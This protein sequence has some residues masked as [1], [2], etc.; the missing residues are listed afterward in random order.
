[1]KRRGVN[2]LW[3]PIF[4]LAIIGVLLFSL[5]VLAEGGDVDPY[6]LG[7]IEQQTVFTD[8]GLLEI[9]AMLINIFM[10][11]L[12]MIAVILMIYAGYLWMT[13]GGNPEK[14]EKARMIIQRA[15]IGL[16]IIFSAWA[17]VTFVFYSLGV[18][19]GDGGRQSCN[20]ENPCPPGYQCVDGRCNRIPDY[21]FRTRE[22]ELT[23]I[24]G[25]R[26]QSLDWSRSTSRYTSLVPVPPTADFQV[27][28]YAFKRN[29]IIALLALYGGLD[30]QS[31]NN[32]GTYPITISE[33]PSTEVEEWRGVD[34]SAVPVG[35]SIYVKN[36]ANSL[37]PVSDLQSSFES[38]LLTLRVINQH[39]FNGV[40]DGDETEIDCGGSCGACAGQSCRTLEDDTCSDAN[41]RSG[42][43]GPDCVCVTEPTIV[44]VVEDDG[45][46]GNYITIYGHHFG[47]EQGQVH[48]YTTDGTLSATVNWTAFPDECSNTWQTGHIIAVV[49]ALSAGN[50]QIVVETSDG[51][52][53]EGYAF[54]VNTVNRPGVC[55]IQNTTLSQ[56]GQLVYGFGQSEN[57]VK[58]IGNQYPTTVDGNNEVQWLYQ[59]YSQQTGGY[60]DDI[61]NSPSN[62]WSTVN[63]AFDVV[64]VG[65]DG[66][67]AVRVSLEPTKNSNPYP[68][69]I[70]AGGVGDPCGDP[71]EQVCAAAEVC[72]P[73]LVC[74]FED[75][76][77]QLG[78]A[79]TC[80]NGQ[81]DQGEQCDSSAEAIYSQ[82]DDDNNPDCSLYGDYLP[83]RNV[84]CQPNCTV[85]VNPCLLASLAGKPSQHNIYSWAFLNMSGTDIPRPGLCGNNI[86]DDG[87]D[88]EDVDGSLTYRGDRSTCQAYGFNSGTLACSNC[89]LDTQNC[90]GASIGDKASSH[91]I[92]GW[93]IGH[94][95]DYNP[96]EEE[97]TIVEDCTRERT[98]RP[99]ARLPSPTPWSEGW[100]SATNINVENPLACLDAII[101]ARFSLPMDV[102]TI[103]PDNIKV[104]KRLATG[105]WQE[106]A[107]DVVA[108]LDSDKMIIGSDNSDMDNDYFRFI[109][110]TNLE[111]NAWYKVVV[112][113][114]VESL[115]GRQMRLNRVDQARVND[116]ECNVN[117]ITDAAYCWNF[118]T[119]SAGTC[120]PGC[121]ECS[122][123]PHTMYWQGA[124]TK[125]LADVDSQDNVCLLLKTGNTDWNWS[126]DDEPTDVK[127]SLGS[128]NNFYN[129]GT[130]IDENIFD[131]PGYTKIITQLR[132]YTGKE[133]FCRAR[134]DF[135]NPVVVE[136]SSCLYGNIQSPSPWISS[137]DACLN[138]MVSARFSRDMTDETLNS[139]NILV[140]QC[141][142]FDCDL[143]GLTPMTYGQVEIFQYSHVLD[144]VTAQQIID[145]GE[146]EDDEL[147]EGFY[148]QP[149]T[150][151][152]PDGNFRFT[153]NTWYRVV[154]K[155]DTEGV[156]GS[157]GGKLLRT[158]YAHDA[159]GE[160]NDYTWKF[161]TAGNDC[162]VDRVT[163][164]PQKRSMSAAGQNQIYHALSVAANCNLLNSASFSWAWRSLYELDDD[165][166]ANDPDYGNAS[167]VARVC[168]YNSNALCDYTALTSEQSS[169]LTRSK[170]RVFGIVDSDVYIKARAL[171]T[172]PQSA[173]AGYNP[174]DPEMGDKWDYGTLRIGYSD[175]K[176]IGHSPDR[177]TCKIPTAGNYSDYDIR[178]RFNIDVDTG[179]IKPGVNTFLYQCDPEN[180]D[181]HPGTELQTVDLTRLN[182]TLYAKEIVLNPNQQLSPYT[183]NT[184][185]LLIQGGPN[186]DRPIAFNG[187]RLMTFNYNSAGGGAG[188]ECEPDILPWSDFS[189]VC[190]N[191]MLDSSKNLCTYANGSFAEC[192]NSL[193]NSSLDYCNDKCFNTGNE[194]RAA[195]GDDYVNV[196]YEQ[197]DDGNIISGDGCS[198]VCLWEG[199]GSVAGSVCGNGEQEEGEACDDG[200]LDNINECNNNCLLTETPEPGSLPYRQCR[201]E[202]NFTVS[203]GANITPP[204]IG[205]AQPFAGTPLD[206]YRSYYVNSSL[207][208]NNRHTPW[209]AK[210][211][212]GQ[213]MIEAQ[214]N[215]GSSA[216]MTE[217]E[218]DSDHYLVKTQIIANGAITSTDDIGL[219]FGYQDE[220]NFW[221]LN[222]ADVGYPGD[223]ADTYRRFR[224][225]N[226]FGQVAITATP[227]NVDAPNH[228]FTLSVE[229]INFS[230][231]ALIKCF[232][233][234]TLLFSH[235]VDRRVTGQVGLYA[236][237]PD[238]SVFFN[239][240]DIIN[241]DSQSND[242]CNTFVQTP[243]C[244]N[245]T[246]E[247]GEDC[248]DGNTDSGDGCSSRCLHE[249]SVNAVCGDGL[250]QTGQDDSYSWVFIVDNTEEACASV[251]P[252]IVMGPCP[253]AIW[254]IKTKLVDENG[255]STGIESLNVKIEAS[256]LTVTHQGWWP[257]FKNWF[258]GLFGQSA[259]AVDYPNPLFDYTF[260]ATELSGDLRQTPS[261][262]GSSDEILGYRQQEEDGNVYYVL[263]II[264]G[265]NWTIDRHY[266]I[267]TTDQADNQTAVETYI[268]PD[269]CLIDDLEVNVWP[270]GQLALED[271]F[272]CAEASGCDR[273]QD[274]AT[275]GNQ[276]IY[277]IWATNGRLGDRKSFLR[278]TSTWELSVIPDLANVLTRQDASA[279]T[280][281]G[282]HWIT[283][284]GRT[285]GRAS[286]RVTA[287]NPQ[288]NDDDYTQSIYLLVFLC[289]NPWPDPDNFPFIDSDNNCT[290][291]DCVNTNFSLGYC[292]D[293]GEPGF[294]DDLP[295]LDENVRVVGM[296][297]DLNIVKQMFFQKMDDSVNPAVATGDTIGLRVINNNNYYN[298]RTWFVSQFN[299]D[300]GA[301]S[302]IDGYQSVAQG[303][304]S[305]IHAADLVNNWNTE[306]KAYSTNYV[307]TYTQT[308]DE[309]IV[310]IYNQ[311]LN[312][313]FF[314]YGIPEQGGLPTMGSCKGTS[315]ACWSDA[316]CD[317]LGPNAYCTSDKAKLTR[318]LRR[319]ADMQDIDLSLMQYK[320]V[321]RCSGLP[322]RLCDNQDDCEGYGMCGNFYPLLPSGTYVPARSISVWPSWQATLGN[323]LGRALP[324]DP[325]NQFSGCSSPYEAQTCWAESLKSFNCSAVATA[326]ANQSTY[327]YIYL[328]S[329]P[330]ETTLSNVR[331]LLANNEF[332]PNYNTLWQ[333][334]PLNLRNYT[335]IVTHTLFTDYGAFFIDDINGTF[336]C[337]RDLSL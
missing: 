100:T 177:L 38:D 297:P 11:L 330:D 1:M 151:G 144:D 68:F 39:C 55:T 245:G 235:E 305:Y 51:L 198:N 186:T 278:S 257:K 241:L 2:N 9:I 286:L 31:L 258:W 49:P 173:V 316:D 35:E 261:I 239:F 318:D 311:M 265:Q 42:V 138:A 54:E 327:N 56:P 15:V 10:G 118:Q 204:D 299:Q 157:T 154:I 254:R 16:I 27:R 200:D 293:A 146:P 329:R 290:G 322:T 145:L 150:G 7:Q 213:V 133:D 230:D 337:A 135:T 147:P 45:A 89:Q 159:D 75:C 125:Y 301:M 197:C 91:A 132:S 225:I 176:V 201:I 212:G 103:N 81:I 84:T 314:N 237:D 14:V 98:C 268:E 37:N 249:G 332:Y 326:L 184:Y 102:D 219:A 46:P 96:G 36:R 319:L 130:A 88:C 231:G 69:L 155:G 206:D 115:S 209:G 124:T 142:D 313:L 331:Y 164:T 65:Q 269:I 149:I 334:L 152:N 300:P 296:N 128:T 158:N 119:R 281:Q 29:E 116:R 216:L 66:R 83:G 61:Y 169:W 113:Q 226:Q 161:K 270:K 112:R 78:E 266:R 17:I 140:Y 170:V 41:C 260:T 13:A 48:F 312:N 123:D 23:Y 227:F 274:T 183:S 90:E 292:R 317:S 6:G 52:L 228:N 220:N 79:E 288:T 298:P 335:D 58:L 94:T 153:P 229:V 178:V 33:T 77:C 25:V 179:S 117:G 85:N 194:N 272:F 306:K 252:E 243:I 60:V 308:G 70:S 109:P 309:D 199:A 30:E 244:G 320:S 195:C 175:L 19:V 53:S 279:T 273:D 104:L 107:G 189:G 131:S 95:G 57:E 217:T 92:Y 263:N 187:K 214:G 76:T 191:C 182:T 294:A 264:P 211:I 4:A 193:P 64:P 139:G 250:V 168:P 148:I 111:P 223:R 240:L 5:P 205:V 62:T 202:D 304:T 208:G 234:N 275:P 282:D 233:D 59:T 277:R 324:V 40:L 232:R 328:S 50:Y 333:S 207:F 67:T 188:E 126:T 181:C 97:P 171:E 210:I 26:S 156:R 86:L 221:L 315:F 163:V 22:G 255:V 246:V 215:E 120:N 165:R 106:V 71:E 267:T 336:N 8:T 72:Q 247:T 47:H 44:L 302:T 32:L 180:N 43:C 236:R 287:G 253:N 114:T 248:D 310:N 74:D 28:G 323:A 280:Y 20:E 224:L 283:A 238:T 12:G 129:T 259:V 160:V 271:T 73:G 101:L 136:D 108:D 162:Q 291:G 303:P 143:T 276:H 121:V 196:G 99:G 284:Q 137:D 141:S 167:D 262:S 285:G 80:G 185:R 122:P 321:E 203:L 134:V 289:D 93:I 21:N 172:G 105:G 190:N 127:V 307:L 295:R 18:A 63:E 192:Q 218:V 222:W 325:I 251:E 34:L 24:S 3:R 174:L 87:E 256:N 242:W 82:L 166:D 110:T